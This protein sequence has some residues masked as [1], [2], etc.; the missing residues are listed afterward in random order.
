[1]ILDYYRRLDDVH[2]DNE[3]IMLRGAWSLG[4]FASFSNRP[5]MEVGSEWALTLYIRNCHINDMIYSDNDVNPYQLFLKFQG[6]KRPLLTVIHL[7]E[8]ATCTCT[9]HVLEK[10][11]IV[12]HTGRWDPKGS[13]Q[14][15]LPIVGQSS[16]I[17]F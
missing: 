6:V 12:R 16:V 9:I 7:Q 2:Q 4:S 5:M 1:M 3:S 15:K 10:D 8:T 11:S 17:V 14:C 13:R